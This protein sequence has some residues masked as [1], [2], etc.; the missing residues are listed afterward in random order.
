MFSDETNSDFNCNRAYVKYK[1]FVVG[2][3]KGIFSRPLSNGSDYHYNIIIKKRY[4]QY[5][6][7]FQSRCHRRINISLP[8]NIHI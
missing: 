1:L 5:N 7:T 6:L 3:K 8:R 2:I 4:L